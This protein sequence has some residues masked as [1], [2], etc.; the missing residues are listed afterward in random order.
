MRHNT[1]AN[2]KSE[3]NCK[4]TWTVGEKG[5]RI[6]A[7]ARVPACSHIEP[8]SKT[9]PARPVRLRTK[10]VTAVAIRSRRIGL[11]R[12]VYVKCQKRPNENKLSYGSGRRK[13]QRVESL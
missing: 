3:T 6:G 13:W 7:G 9:L 11:F 12:C 4:A 5:E 1:K 2:T 10:P 8:R